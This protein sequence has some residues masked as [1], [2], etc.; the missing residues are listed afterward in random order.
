M[1]TRKY[2]IASY[3]INDKRKWQVVNI[4]R[5]RV[6]SRCTIGRPGRHRLEGPGD[7]CASVRLYCYSYSL[8]IDL[9]VAGSVLLE[10]E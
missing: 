4:V 2:A 9:V 1:L 10:L 7:R 5:M 6:T 3:A 8:K